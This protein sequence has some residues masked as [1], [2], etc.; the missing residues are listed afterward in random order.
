MAAGYRDRVAFGN[1]VITDKTA[2]A[3]DVPIGL[4]RK[5]G[6]SLYLLD[7]PDYIPGMR[8]FLREVEQSFG[9]KAGTARSG[10]PVHNGVT[11]ILTPKK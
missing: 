9:A 10:A 6:L 1:A 7:L 8:D 2:V 11:A 4:L 3:K 5:M